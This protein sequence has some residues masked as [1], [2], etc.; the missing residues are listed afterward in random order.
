MYNSHCISQLTTDYRLGTDLQRLCGPVG[1]R[2]NCAEYHTAPRRF[3][4][5]SSLY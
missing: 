3:L 2:E 4:L 1:V 5:A